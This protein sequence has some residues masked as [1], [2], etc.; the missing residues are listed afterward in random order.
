MRGGDH[1]A[2]GIDIGR[3]IV[4]LGSMAKTPKRAAVSTVEQTSVLKSFRALVGPEEIVEAGR[5]LGMIQRDRKLDLAA[6]VE[7]TILAVWPT[8]GR[9]C[10]AV[11]RYSTPFAGSTNESCT[12]RPNP[13]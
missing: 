6:L 3:R 12:T 2:E 13:S 8:P 10:V 7:S 1:L 5:R 4:L 9:Y 11:A